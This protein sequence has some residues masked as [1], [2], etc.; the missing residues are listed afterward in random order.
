MRRL[1]PSQRKEMAKLL[2][3]YNTYGSIPAFRQEVW[4]TLP[5]PHG[6]TRSTKEATSPTRLLAS[7]LLEEKMGNISV[8]LYSSQMCLE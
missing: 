3:T 5:S 8:P 4:T 7:Q 1:L 6:P 2:S